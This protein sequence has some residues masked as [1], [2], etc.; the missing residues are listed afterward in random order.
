MA[1]PSSASSSSALLTDALAQVRRALFKV[2]ALSLGLNLLMLTAPLYMFQVFDRVLA[3]GRVETLILLTVVA[4]FALMTYGALEAIRQRFLARISSWLGVVASDELIDRSVR[5]ATRGAKFGGQPLR[6]LQTVRTFLGGQGVTPFFDAP[7][8]PLFLGVL[9]LLHPILGLVATAAAVVLAILALCNEIFTRKPLSEAG[10]KQNQLLN[11]TDTAVANAEVLEAMGMTPGLVRKWQSQNDEVTANQQ[12]AA[13]RS[14]MLLGATKFTRLF[15]QVGILGVGAY[16]VLQGQ[17]TAGAMI[18]GS[19]LMSR[20]LAPVE[21]AISAWRSLVN[22][23]NA[24]GRLKKVVQAMPDR[25]ESISLP[26][27]KGQLDLSGVAYAPPGSNKPIIRGVSFHLDPGE[28]MGLIGPSASGKSTLCRLIVGVAVPQSGSVRLD[29]AEI[30][31]WDARERGPY[32]GYMPQDVELFAGTVRDNIA[33]LRSDAPDEDVIK[34]AQKAGVHEMVLQLPK[35][36]ETEI[37]PRGAQ[38]SG[39]QR[40]RIGLARALFG[41]PRLI[42]LDEPNASLDQEGEKALMDAIA[43]ARQSGATVILVAHRPA[44]M[45]HASKVMVLRD[46]QVEAFGPKDEVLQKVMRLASVQQGK[47][48]QGGEGGQGGQGGKG[49]QQGTPPAVPAAAVGG[50]MMGDGS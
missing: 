1:A 20:A 45:K 8:M 19:V 40:Q 41:E 38:L 16:L 21:Q 50:D 26:A 18:A 12:T 13:D 32:I 49:G 43:A 7:W 44:L 14:G 29:G 10:S 2:G 25:E 11:Q 5:A 31:Q 24:Y 34:A 6:D 39:G 23:R 17:L 35:G 3:S 36:Y 27:P 42:V 46:G 48:G 47:G 15:V 4:G 28:A 9:F 37:G 33:R 30:S 22:A